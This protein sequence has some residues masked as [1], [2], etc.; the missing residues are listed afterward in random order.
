M[1]LNYKNWTVLNTGG[2]EQGQPGP[3]CLICPSVMAWAIYHWPSPRLNSLALSWA[4]LP[5]QPMAPDSVNT[6]SHASPKLGPSP[7][8]HLPIEQNQPCLGQSLWLLSGQICHLEPC[9]P[10]WAPAAHEEVVVSLPHLWWRSLVFPNNTKSQANW[11]VVFLTETGMVNMMGHYQM[12]LDLQDHFGHLVVWGCV[13]QSG[14]L[15]PGFWSSRSLD[16][17]AFDTKTMAIN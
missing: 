16:L 10:W 12:P 5:T 8:D 14:Y 2:M 11:V 4:C 3:L 6:A 7:N 9:L 17:A 13:P 1:R 15:I